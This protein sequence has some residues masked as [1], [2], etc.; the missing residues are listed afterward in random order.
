MYTQA[1]A[2]PMS[3]LNVLPTRGHSTN[4]NVFLAQ[5]YKAQRGLTTL[6]LHGIYIMSRVAHSDE[7]LIQLVLQKV[8]SVR[9]D[10]VPQAWKPLVLTCG[11]APV[12]RLGPADVSVRVRDN[13]RQDDTLVCSH[14]VV[15]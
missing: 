15:I 9:V 11:E 1:Y 8:F 12:R 6:P 2:L 7:E 4:K 5:K 3:L 13:K 14:S 10:S